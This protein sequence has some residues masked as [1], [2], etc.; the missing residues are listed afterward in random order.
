MQLG[1]RH[2]LFLKMQI[3]KIGK[4]ELTGAPTVFSRLNKN[5]QNN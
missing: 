1:R 4:Y 2:E 5:P 3:L